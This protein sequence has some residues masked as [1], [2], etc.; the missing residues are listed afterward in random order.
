MRN[1]GEVPQPW[2]N[3]GLNSSTTTWKF[4]HPK[5]IPIRLSSV[6]GTLKEWFHHSDRPPPW[7]NEWLHIIHHKMLSPC[8]HSWS[9]HTLETIHPN[10]KPQ[11]SDSKIQTELNPEITNASHFLLYILETLN[12]DHRRGKGGRWRSTFP[13]VATAWPGKLTRMSESKSNTKRRHPLN[14]GIPQKPSQALETINP[15]PKSQRVLPKFRPTR[16]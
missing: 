3:N 10:P 14:N 1:Q 5:R 4:Y 16:A 13:A 6:R 15:N 11:K 7:D 8:R 9:V 12:G 2:H